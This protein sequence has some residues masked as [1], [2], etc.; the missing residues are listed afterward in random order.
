MTP[1]AWLVGLVFPACAAP[2]VQGL[3][4]PG[5]MD[6]T[7]IERPASPNTALAAPAGFRPVPDITVPPY[8]VAPARLY[9]VV[10]AVA[11]AQPQTFV[12]AEYPTELQIHWVVRSAVL[13]FPDMITAQIAADGQDSSTL[14][15]YSRSVYGYSDFGVNRQRVTTWLAA[16]QTQLHHTAER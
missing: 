4:Q 9:A 13:N 15:L 11:A 14:V 7:R 3:P 5:P 8:P 10:R 6:M 1:L 12:A 2:G 16:V